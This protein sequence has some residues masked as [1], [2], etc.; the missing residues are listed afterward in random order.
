MPLVAIAQV[1][2]WRDLYSPV[3]TGLVTSQDQAAMFPGYGCGSLAADRSG[4]DQLRRM[5]RELFT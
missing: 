1:V 4:S 3:V 2:T 5:S